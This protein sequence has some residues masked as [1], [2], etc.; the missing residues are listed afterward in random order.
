MILRRRRGQNRRCRYGVCSAADY[1]L[2]IDTHWTDATEAEKH[3]GW[4]LSLSDTLKAYSSGSY[5]LN[6]LGDEEPAAIS[7]AIGEITRDWCTQDHVRSNRLLQ[8]QPELG[9]CA[10]ARACSG[11]SR[12]RL[13]NLEEQ[14][15]RPVNG[16]ALSNI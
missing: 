6:F 9:V 5:L 13:F 12:A 1:H 14:R 11:N 3:I 7:A 16:Q 8:P 2:G 4:T 15:G 10:A